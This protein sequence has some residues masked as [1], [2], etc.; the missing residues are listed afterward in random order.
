MFNYLNVNNLNCFY[1]NH[2]ILED[3]TFSIKKKGDI[4]CFLGPSGVGKT[5]L[6]R[7]IAG[8][9]KNISG[10]IK[11][12]EKLISSNS[13]NLS[14]EYRN[15]ALSFQE[16]CLFPN[17][18]ILENINIGLKKSH[19]KKININNLISDFYLGGIL[20][21][22]PHEISTGEAQRVSILR[23][24]ATEPELLLL[25]EPFANIDQNLKEE[26]QIKLKIFLKKNLI[27]TIIVTHDSNEAFYFGDECGLILDKKIEQIDTPYNIHHR[28]VSE[29]VAKFLNRGNFINA[30]VIGKNKLNHKVLGLIKGSFSNKHKIGTEVK[31]LIQPEDLTHDDKSKL[32]L[33]IIDIKFRGSNFNYTLQLNEKE[34]II[35]QVHSHH[36]HQHKIKEYFGIKLPIIINHLVCF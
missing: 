15:I 17:K 4:T 35:V 26:L 23:S 9:E 16:N 24:L 11:L 27:S 6:L 3:I 32:K 33:K 19:K 22:Y 25:D 13:F 36:I 7:A 12:N 2:V 14:P 8:L 18:T 1:G 28:P 34:N 29:K 31:L 20:N 21:Q 30:F 10:E 5:T